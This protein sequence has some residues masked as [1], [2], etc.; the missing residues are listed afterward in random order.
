VGSIETSEG[1]QD[2][3]PATVRVAFHGVEESFEKTLLTKILEVLPLLLTTVDDSELVDRLKHLC[4]AFQLEDWHVNRD[5]EFLLNGRTIIER[6]FKT[7]PLLNEHDVRK[8]MASNPTFNL[9]D[10]LQITYGG[11]THY[12]ADQF[13][14]HDSIHAECIECWN[15]LKA[16]P[17]SSEWERAWWWISSTGWLESGRA[18]RDVFKED[19]EGVLDAARREA[20][21]DYH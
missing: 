17:R 16:D 10:L 8:R 2:Y 9:S 11:H 3:Y 21:E 6:F 15:A 5:A 18:P 19:R 12:F 14:S 4:R 20:L 13:D 1:I 7:V